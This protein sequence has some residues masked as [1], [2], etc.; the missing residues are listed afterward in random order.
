MRMMAI[1]AGFAA[2]VS[3][4]PAAEAEVVYPWCFHEVSEAG[5]VSCAYATFDQCM[6]ARLG[7]GGFC[8]RNALFDPQA[9]RR[10]DA[11]KP[12]RKPR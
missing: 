12:A 6:A 2:A 8:G 7:Q 5:Y 3:G 10:S 4:I 11:A 1:A 9:A